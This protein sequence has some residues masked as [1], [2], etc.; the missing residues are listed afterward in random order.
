MSRPEIEPESLA[1]QINRYKQTNRI[2]PICTYTNRS[3]TFFFFLYTQKYYQNKPISTQYCSL[4]VFHFTEKTKQIFFQIKFKHSTSVVP[5][6]TD[7][8]ISARKL[9]EII[10]KNKKICCILCNNILW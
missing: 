7:I 1:F 9:I 2:F 4:V 10:I 3:L 8:H 5:P 6:A